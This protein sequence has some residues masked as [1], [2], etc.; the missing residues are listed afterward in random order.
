MKMGNTLPAV[1]SYY[2]HCVQWAIWCR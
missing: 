1:G 2:I